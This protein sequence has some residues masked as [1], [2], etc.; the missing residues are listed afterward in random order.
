MKNKL[1]QIILSLFLVSS[2]LISSCGDSGEI[3]TVQTPTIGNDVF[4]ATSGQKLANSVIS[5]PKSLQAPTQQ[6]APSLKSVA[7]MMNSQG[8]GGMEGIYT[9]ITH[10]VS[11]VEM[12]TV[13]LKEIMSGIVQNSSILGFPLGQEIDLSQYATS[14][15]DP[16]KLIVNKPTASGYDWKI[17]LFDDLAA[18]AP[19]MVIYFTLGTDGAKGKLVM[20]ITE[21]DEQLTA[22][23]ITGINKNVTVEAIF[24][25]TTTLKTL[26]VKFIQDMTEIT[27]YAQT[28]WATLTQVQKD[29]FDLGQP[30]RVFLNAS[31]DGTEYT[32]Y[33][34]SYH[35][36]WAVE[37]TLNNQPM[38]WGND[39]SIYMFKAK[40]LEGTVNGSKLSLAL[41]VE[42]ATD[43][44]NSWTNDSIGSIFT[45]IQL[46]NINGFI[47]RYFDAVD[48]A[49]VS[50]DVSEENT[51]GVW[52]LTWILGDNPLIDPL[53]THGSTFTQ[54][55]YDAAKAF[56]I[57]HPDTNLTSVFSIVNVADYNAFFASLSGANQQSW[58]TITM[59][60]V[61]KANYLAG[62]GIT[63]TQLESF[64]SQASSDPNVIN[65]QNQ[66][67]AIQ[68]M[69]NPAFYKETLGFIGTYDEASS[70]F[71]E[72]GAGTFNENIDTTSIDDLLILD[73]N[74]ITSY[75]PVEVINATILVQ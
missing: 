9:G 10:Y 36:G 63:K 75:T 4:N 2:L 47:D 23:G 67:K 66:Y 42:T 41:P 32:I 56:W 61:I 31:Y 54:A 34:T 30:E 25:A 37:A 39:R 40:S 28:N 51:S 16:Q 74:T 52:T 72:Y 11:M 33:G 38:F 18:T 73:L 15:D 55:E 17:S 53:T 50:G 22:I 8:G 46:D 5:L 65:F 62:S 59:A 69:I 35:P 12:M 48:D 64:I 29:A 58:Y 26:D 27:A 19:Q 3:T 44:T 70:T 1:Y 43:V 57:N 60:P 68:Y 14:P 13:M 49:D 21:P 20:Q 24:D 71:Y 6:P 7:K 45:Q